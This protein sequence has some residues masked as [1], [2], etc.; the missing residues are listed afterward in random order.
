MQARAV[1]MYGCGSFSRV[2]DQKQKITGMVV[3]ALPDTNFRVQL[4]DGRILLVYLAGKMRLH[5]IKVMLGDTV[6]VELA[7]DGSRGRIV[8]RN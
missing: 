2:A 6:T 4:P 5:R 1:R 3:E 8:Y 7:P